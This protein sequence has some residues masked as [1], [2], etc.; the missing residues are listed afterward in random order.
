M[1]KV[2][3]S[4]GQWSEA[5]LT[6]ALKNRYAGSA[7]AFLPQVANG[8]G[9]AKSRT[10]D[11][12]VMSLWPSR[13]LDLIG[14]EIK[15]SRND[16]LSELKRPEKAESIARYCNLWYLVVSSEDIVKSGELPSAWGLLAPKGT[17]LRIVKEAVQTPAEPISR[18]FLA[19][20]LRNAAGAIVPR[21]EI[22]EEL[23]REHARGLRDGEERARYKQTSSDRDLAQL[24]TSVENFERASGLRID[25]YNGE[26]LGK[27]AALIRTRGMEHIVRELEMIRSRARTISDSID[28][29]IAEVTSAP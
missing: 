20:L 15:I 11:A 13:G 6:V 3:L 23:K 2:K 14:F 21:A 18:T 7:Y 9:A 10:A 19:A 12:L 28:N 5:A 29:T 25:G 16:W 8:T 17:V 26:K 1:P 27:A 4:K 22:D 24:K